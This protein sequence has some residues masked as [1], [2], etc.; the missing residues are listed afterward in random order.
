MR[1]TWRTAEDWGRIIYSFFSQN[2]LLGTV[3]TFY[4]LHSGDL[5]HGT[6]RKA[7]RFALLLSLNMIEFNGLDVNICLKAV[8]SLVRVGQAQIFNSDAETIDETGFKLI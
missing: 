7:F 8:E 2:S 5:S 6:G 3:Y 1:I 4:E